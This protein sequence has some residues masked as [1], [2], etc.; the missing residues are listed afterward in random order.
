M[1]SMRRLLTHVSNCNDND[2][3]VKTVM[4]VM[5]IMAMVKIMMEIKKRAPAGQIVVDR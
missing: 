1:I 3:N 4:M 2:D 5:V